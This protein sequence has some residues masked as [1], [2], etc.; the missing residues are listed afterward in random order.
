M[1]DTLR[2]YIT[3]HQRQ[4]PTWANFHA[5]FSLS[6]HKASSAVPDMYRG[7]QVLYYSLTNAAPNPT[8]SQLKAHLPSKVPIIQSLP[9]VPQ[10][11]PCHNWQP[12]A[13]QQQPSL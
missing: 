11:Q 9:V 13:K 2:Q 5:S 7:N 1:Q 12:Q 6:L 4:A 8:G 3:A 10:Q